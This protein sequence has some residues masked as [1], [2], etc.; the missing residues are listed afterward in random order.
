MTRIQPVEILWLC[1]VFYDSPSVHANCLSIAQLWL[2]RF[3]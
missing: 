2:K 1:E 3:K